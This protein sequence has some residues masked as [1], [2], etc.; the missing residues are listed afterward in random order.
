MCSESRDRPAT[1]EIEVT[2]AMIQAGVTVMSMYNPDC[3]ELSERVE[4]TFRAMWR[5]RKPGGYT[6]IAEFG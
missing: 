6:S 1:E 2:P 3:E 5:L 4:M